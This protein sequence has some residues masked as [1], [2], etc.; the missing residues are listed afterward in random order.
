MRVIRLMA[1]GASRGQLD[2]ARRLHVTAFAGDGGMRPAQGEA[3]TCMVETDRLPVRGL[4]ARC[5]ITAIAAL[6]YV[7]HCVAAEACHRRTFYF[8]ALAVTLDAGCG[9]VRAGQRKARVARM[10]EVHELPA[11]RYMAAFTFGAFRPF[12]DIVLKMAGNAGG[13][14]SFEDAVRMASLAGG[15]AMFA[16]EVEARDRMIEFACVGPLRRG[17]ATFA[18]FSEAAVV[19]VVL[20]VAGD[21]S[22]G[23]RSERL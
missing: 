7:I 3:E 12:V 14:R 8:L 21:A 15:L 20:L 19:L 17:V 6:V 18:L 2:L 10:I 13:R 22:G 1:A 5:A 11:G 23:C 16:E 9:A 4:V